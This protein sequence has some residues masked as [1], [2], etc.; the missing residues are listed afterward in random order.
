[1]E[2]KNVYLR[3]TADA[4]CQMKSRRCEVAT[5]QNE[6]G[7]W[8]DLSRKVIDEPLQ[9]FDMFMTDP[10]RQGIRPFRWFRHTEI[11]AE[12]KEE[13]LQG[14]QDTSDFC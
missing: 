5:G 7:Q 1:M 12:V 10:I 2:S 14:C 8:T 4:S 11:S 13:L 9:L 6:T 3:T